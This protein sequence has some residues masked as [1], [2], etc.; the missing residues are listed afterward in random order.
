MLRSTLRLLAHIGTALV[1]LLVGIVLI[2]AIRL[3]VGPVSVPWIVPQIQ[4]VLNG[5]H[6]QLRFT[7]SEA[8]VSW[9]GWEHFV[10]LRLLDLDATDASGRSIAH[11]PAL[12]KISRM[13]TDEAFRNEIKTAESP[14]A[15]YDM[16]S[17]HE[18]EAA[19]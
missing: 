16:I 4:S 1:A 14:E 18:A 5:T 9:L 10:A 2:V 12:A 6:D 15:L 13:L 7:I 19:V 11:I 8:E 3:S 17:Q